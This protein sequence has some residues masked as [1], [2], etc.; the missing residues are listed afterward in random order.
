MKQ[1]V[2]NRSCLMSTERERM[3]VAGGVAGLAWVVAAGSVEAGGPTPTP[4]LSGTEMVKVLRESS[5]PMSQLSPMM[6]RRR[7][8]S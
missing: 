1:T 4:E 2:D 5:T 6:L 7:K 3:V 8:Q